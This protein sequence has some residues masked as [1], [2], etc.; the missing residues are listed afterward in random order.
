MLAASLVVAAILAA[1]PPPDV[2]AR[3]LVA[4][5]EARMRTA[6]DRM[7]E[8]TATFYQREWMDGALQEAQ[9]V[10]MKW[11]RADATH[12]DRLYMKWTAGLHKGRELLWRGGATMRVKAGIIALDV[13]PSGIL[14]RGQARHHVREA[15]LAHLVERIVA[16]IVRA[17]ARKHAG[18]RYGDLGDKNVHGALAHCYVVD[19]PKDEDPGFYAKRSEIC[20]DAKSSLPSVVKIWDE[21][22]GKLELVEDYSFADIRVNPGLSDDD[23]SPKN[24]AYFD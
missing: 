4:R 6:A 24:P 19:L 20:I 12:G 9:H 14:A 15:G 11:R 18:V 8:H 7:Q 16:D 1:A 23:F 17:K 21:I 5:M 10:Q 2:A 13:D 3:A 22:D